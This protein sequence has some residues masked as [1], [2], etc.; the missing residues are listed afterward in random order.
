[1]KRQRWHPSQRK[2]K[3]VTDGIWTL[4]NGGGWGGKNH[5]WETTQALVRETGKDLALPVSGE[6]A[7]AHKWNRYVGFGWALRLDGATYLIR[8]E[9]E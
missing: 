6:R 5:V 4:V 9:A 2:V 8:G 7:D 1:M 3:P